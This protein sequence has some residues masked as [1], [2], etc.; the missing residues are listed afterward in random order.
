MTYDKEK[1]LTKQQ[2]RERV[3]VYG[4][5]LLG[6]SDEILDKLYDFWDE[7]SGEP[8]YD[9]DGFLSRF[10]I[11]YTWSDWLEYAQD[12]NLEVDLNNPEAVKNAVLQDVY[13]RDDIGYVDETDKCIIYS[14]Q[15]LQPVLSD[16]L[17]S[18]RQPTKLL[19]HNANTRNRDWYFF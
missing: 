6:A 15:F 17:F 11:S 5:A 16:W 7:N 13:S 19:S 18:S 10:I 8:M 2:F 1:T 4:S 14:L 3:R 9:D 12:N